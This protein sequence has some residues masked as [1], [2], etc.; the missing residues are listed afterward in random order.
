[1]PIDVEHVPAR[2][3]TVRALCERHPWL[4]Y[5]SLRRAIFHSRSNGLDIAIVRFG[6]RNLIDEDRFLGWV[7]SGA[8]RT[9]APALASAAARRARG[10]RHGGAT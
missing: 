8:A 9:L 5:G 2:L 7:R 6:S 1:M 4:S 3:L 10:S